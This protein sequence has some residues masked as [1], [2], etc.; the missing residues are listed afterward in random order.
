M[1]ETKIVLNTNLSNNNHTVAIYGRY[2][3]DYSTTRPLSASA[4]NAGFNQKVDQ[5]I[6]FDLQ[7]SYSF[8]LSGNDIRLS[9]GG[10]NILDEDVPI[11]Y[12]A[13]N[14]SY[15]PKQHDPRGRLFYFGLKLLR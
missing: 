11:V 14:F 6:T 10:N 9:I 5:W 12:D 15:D 2:V 4:K 1:P 3:S 7:Y 8:N 13:A